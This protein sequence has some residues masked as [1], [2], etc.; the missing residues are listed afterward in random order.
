MLRGHAAW[1]RLQNFRPAAQ[2]AGRAANH[3]LGLQSGQ[4]KTRTGSKGCATVKKRFA[5]DGAGHEPSLQPVLHARRGQG[6]ARRG[7][8][9]AGGQGHP[10]QARHQPQ[11][12]TDEER[13]LAIRQIISK[14]V[15][16]ESVVDI[17]DAVGLDKPNIGLLDEEFPGP[18]EEPAREEPGGRAAGAPC[19]KA[20]SS[21]AATN[22]VQQKKFSDLLAT[23]SPATRTVP[24]RPRR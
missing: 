24:S 3:I 4:R 7:R 2:D 1:L 23:S 10:D 8:L 9:P 11:K 13:D 19:S 18:G 5:D 15:V 6:G 12:K 16:S 22:V 20:R 21:P 14:A 17:F